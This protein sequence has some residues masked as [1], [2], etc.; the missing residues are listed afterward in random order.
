MSEGG[1]PN[2]PPTPQS[3]V[4]GDREDMRR[5][6]RDRPAG[7]PIARQ[8]APRQTPPPASPSTQFANLFLGGMPPLSPAPPTPPTY[9]PIE[10]QISER[11]AVL[12][13]LRLEQ[14]AR[15]R[16]SLAQLAPSNPS[17]PL[18]MGGASQYALDWGVSQR[19]L[20]PPTPPSTDS[21]RSGM[22]EI[23]SL[24]DSFDSRMMSVRQSPSPLQ[25]PPNAVEGVASRRSIR[26]PYHSPEGVFN[27]EDE[28]DYKSSSS[29]SG[30][31][32][33]LARYYKK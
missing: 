31:R 18:Q 2:V 20:R 22:S 9:M 19:R 24:T 5:R 30:M 17:N 8:P 15:D 10:R 32:G 1:R 7:T 11:Q 13:R 4:E 33:R 27:F 14:E 16:I 3:E 6:R 26:S 23:S 29:G 21:R 12:E 25:L 28:L